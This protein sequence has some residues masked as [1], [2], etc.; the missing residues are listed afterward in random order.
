MSKPRRKNPSARQKRLARQA[1]ARASR[2]LADACPL[3][4]QR[5]PFHGYDKWM[6][7]TPGAVPPADMPENAATVY[8]I[9]TAL[10]PLYEGQVPYAAIVLEQQIRS[11]VLLVANDAGGVVRV[12]VPDM[13]TVLADT[14]DYAEA[15]PVSDEVLD[16]DVGRLLHELH[17]LAA[18]VV[19]DR[20][21]VGLAALV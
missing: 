21:V 2:T 18:L 14:A 11:G 6:T 13:A 16:S 3:F 12:P 7:P 4:V 17:A 5:P 20:G 10:A 9:V 19:D 8:E 15:L 1:A